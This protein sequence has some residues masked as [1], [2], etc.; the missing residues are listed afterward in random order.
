MATEPGIRVA[1]N[2]EP[3]Q[4]PSGST[5]SDLLERL[6]LPAARV[7]VEL[8][9]RVVPRAEHAAARLTHGDRVEIVTF[10]GGGAA[11]AA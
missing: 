3:L 1:V 9:R 4:L 11:P 6:S 2:G 5:V 10:V 7:A 8:N